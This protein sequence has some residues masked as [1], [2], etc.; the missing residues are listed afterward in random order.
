MT[1]HSFQNKIPAKQIFLFAPQTATSGIYHDIS[2]LM[3]NMPKV[4]NSQDARK[5]VEER[6][7]AYLADMYA[8]KNVL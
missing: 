7:M 5:L 4:T 1:F 2:K 3:V 6:N 8:A